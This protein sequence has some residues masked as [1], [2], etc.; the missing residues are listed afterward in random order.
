[1]WKLLQLQNKNVQFE[2]FAWFQLHRPQLSVSLTHITLSLPWHTEPGHHCILLFCGYRPLDP[3]LLH[4]R[5]YPSLLLLLRHLPHLIL[6]LL[7][8]L[9]LN[10]FAHTNQQRLDEKRRIH[11]C[12]M[13]RRIHACDMKRRIHACHQ[14]LDEKSPRKVSLRALREEAFV[15][16]ELG[17]RV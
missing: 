16:S 17:F 8:P 14:R 9:L 12:D 10:L 11:A 2:A 7:L 13:K 5:S 15:F 6:L 4:R 1:M 3:Q